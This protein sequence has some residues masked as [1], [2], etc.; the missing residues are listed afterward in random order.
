[1]KVVVLWY[2]VTQGV[3]TEIADF[4]YSPLY[5]KTPMER[6]EDTIAHIVSNAVHF[7]YVAN[8]DTGQGALICIVKD[9]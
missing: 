8:R 4:E 2:L 5:D 1:M 6:C 7:P 3:S 9:N